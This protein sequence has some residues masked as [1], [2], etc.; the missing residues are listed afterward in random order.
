MRRREFIALLGGAAASWPLATRAQQP[1]MP[2]VGEKGGARANPHGDIL[3]KEGGSFTG[4]RQRNDAPEHDAGRPVSSGGSRL[5]PARFGSYRKPIGGWGC[6]R[7]YRL[8]SMPCCR[9]R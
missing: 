8:G 4:I 2:V 6:F 3:Q 9:L 1:R 5:E 7:I